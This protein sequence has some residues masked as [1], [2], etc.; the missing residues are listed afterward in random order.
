MNEVRSEIEKTESKLSKLKAGINAI[1]QGIQHF[2]VSGSTYQFY[3]AVSKEMSNY[4]VILYGNS[5]LAAKE[6]ETEEGVISRFWNAYYST[7]DALNAPTE[8]HYQVFK[9]VREQLKTINAKFEILKNQYNDYLRANP[10]LG[11]MPFMW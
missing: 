9:D 2:S 4:N 11:E 10:G 7:F 8:T 3:E 1:S 5:A 6:F